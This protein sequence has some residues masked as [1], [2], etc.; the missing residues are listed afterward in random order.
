MLI[1]PPVQYPGSRMTTAGEAWRQVRNN[2]IV[3]YGGAL[4]LIA[5]GALAILFFARGPIGHADAEDGSQ[6]DR[7]LHALRAFGA[8]GQR[9]RVF[10]PGDLRHRDGV[11]QVL[12]ACP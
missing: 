8:L 5:L 2:W 1:Q 12:P 11:R 9:D 7:A 3:P 4:F 6:Q 10:H